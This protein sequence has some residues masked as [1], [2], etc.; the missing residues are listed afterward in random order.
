[1]DQEGISNIRASTVHSAQGAESDIVFFS[2]AISAKTSKRTYEWIKNNEEIINVATSR[3]KER[4][5]LFSDVSLIEKF[6]KGEGDDRDDLLS[7]IKY[8]KSK[9]E[10]EV[11]N[12]PGS[13]ASFEKSNL[14]KAEDDFHKTVSQLLSTTHN[15]K[16]KRDVPIVDVFPKDKAAKARPKLAYDSVLYRKSW[17]IGGKYVPL[18]VFEIAGGEHYLK[19]QNDLYKAKV[20]KDNFVKYIMVPNEDV[21][22]YERLKD[23]LSIL[24]EKKKDYAQDVQTFVQGTLELGL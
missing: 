7:L 11:L 12:I 6:A 5:Y 20:A 18:A 14:S 23:I 19:A 3:A 24:G 13:Y 4:F 17:L 2:T 16:I 9:G 8:C 15:L 10:V 22:D 21:K 1:M